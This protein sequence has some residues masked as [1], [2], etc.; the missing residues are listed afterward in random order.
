MGY[1]FHLF[2]TLRMALSRKRSS[3]VR[4]VRQ[5]PPHLSTQEN[6]VPVK[7]LSVNTHAVPRRASF[8]YLE[9]AIRE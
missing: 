7:K 1:P 3:D 2:A 8:P 6:A 5:T 4:R 9:A